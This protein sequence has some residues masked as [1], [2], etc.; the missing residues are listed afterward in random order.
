MMNKI[1]TYPS[2]LA[3]VNPKDFDEGDTVVIEDMET[4]DCVPGTVVAVTLQNIYAR[5]P[6]R[7]KY[8]LRVIQ[9]DGITAGGVCRLVSHIKVRS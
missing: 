6:D 9:R 5:F 3:W 7:D 8:F 4:G 1:Q 2:K